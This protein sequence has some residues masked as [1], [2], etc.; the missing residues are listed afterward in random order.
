M[1]D[2]ARALPPEY[3]GP[4]SLTGR[5][6]M[7]ESTLALSGLLVA[8]TSGPA[9]AVGILLGNGD[10][11]FQQPQYFQESGENSLSVAVGDF[12]GDGFLDLAVAGHFSSFPFR[13]SV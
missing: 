5:V 6:A 10:G 13:G 12:N 8:L 9:L 1:L 11:S 2:S 4:D 7:R 3:V